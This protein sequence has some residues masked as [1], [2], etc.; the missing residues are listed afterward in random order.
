MAAERSLTTE[1]TITGAVQARNERGIQIA[2]DQTGEVNW[3]NFSSF[4]G[5]PHAREVA[6]LAAPGAIVRARWQPARLGDTR[7]LSDLVIMVEARAEAAAAPTPIRPAPAPAPTAAA[8]EPASRERSIARAV[9]LKAAIELLVGTPKADHHPD[10]V[11]VVADLF[12]DWLTV[13]QS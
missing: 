7:W 11:L 2:D 8:V 6:D 5:G 12:L 1:Q 4:R 13:D 9:A 10:A 3:Y